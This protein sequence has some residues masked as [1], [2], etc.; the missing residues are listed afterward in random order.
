MCSKIRVPH[1]ASKLI[2]A[3]NCSSKSFAVNKPQSKSKISKAPKLLT[4]ERAKIR[5]AQDAVREEQEKEME[6][7][8]EQVKLLIFFICYIISDQ[9]I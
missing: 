1:N 9:I 3:S 8:K 7:L 5:L 6:V 2:K 4:A